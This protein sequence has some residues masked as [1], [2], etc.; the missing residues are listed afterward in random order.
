VLIP[1]RDFFSLLA[2]QKCKR[3][4]FHARNKSETLEL[5]H[6]NNYKLTK[7]FFSLW[8]DAPRIDPPRLRLIFGARVIIWAACEPACPLTVLYS[9]PVSIYGAAWAQL[10]HKAL[11]YHWENCLLVRGAGG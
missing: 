3:R 7:A 11:V 5:A 8:L 2:G 10:A 1:L 4:R 6:N 9:H